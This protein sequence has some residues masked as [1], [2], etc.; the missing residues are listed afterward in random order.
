MRHGLSAI[1]APAARHGQ[2]WSWHRQVPVAAT[3]FSLVASFPVLSVRRFGRRRTQDQQ[4]PARDQGALIRG[5]PRPFRKAH[6]AGA[7]KR[8]GAARR[9]SG[10]RGKQRKAVTPRGVTAFSSLPEAPGERKRDEKTGTAMR[11]RF[12]KSRPRPRM[13]RPPAIRCGNG[14][15]RG[16]QRQILMSR[17]SK[18]I[19]PAG[20]ST[21]TR[22][23][24][25]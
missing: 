21:S 23:P 10:S 4:R 3:L 2:A 5:T 13:Y 18:W 11:S 15:A 1:S 25:L 6:R 24:F 17:I 14:P 9:G 8:R 7:R 20:T 19:V 22:S 16:A 12:G